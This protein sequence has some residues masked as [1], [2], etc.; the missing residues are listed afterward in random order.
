[1]VMRHTCGAGSGCVVDG[2]AAPHVQLPRGDLIC[3]AAPPANPPRFVHLYSFL[4]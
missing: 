3:H 2:V 4:T 1:M